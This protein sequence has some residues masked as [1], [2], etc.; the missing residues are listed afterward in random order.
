MGWG[1]VCLETWSQGKVLY[2]SYIENKY[3]SIEINDY[4]RITFTH[5]SSPLFK[6]LRLMCY[7][8]VFYTDL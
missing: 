4:I 6:T 2:I 7:L 5:Y 8:A 1:S 3:I